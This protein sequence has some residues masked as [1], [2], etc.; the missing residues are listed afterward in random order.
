MAVSKVNI[1]N[2]ALSGVGDAGEV[3]D[4]AEASRQ[5]NL[6]RLH[7]DNALDAALEVTDWPFARRRARLALI[8]FDDTAEWPYRYALPADCVAA[9]YI[10]PQSRVVF[11]ESWDQAVQGMAP[12]DIPFMVE[13][14]ADG[15]NPTLV[16]VVATPV[17]VYTTRNQ[18]VGTYPA[19]FTNL[20]A[21]N[22]AVLIAFPLTKDR[23]IRADAVAAAQN[24]LLVA[25]SA[26]FAEQKFDRNDRPSVFER[27]RR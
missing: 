1:W 6:C 14:S 24:A 19:V 16:T 11:S 10:D 23:A 2:M 5:A 15:K 25:R 7:Y 26:K 22:L 20:I 27:A 21:A 9:R 18:G 13:G 8:T 3:T 17:L 4:P 12:V